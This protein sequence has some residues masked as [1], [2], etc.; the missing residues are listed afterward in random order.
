MRMVTSDE[1]KIVPRVRFE[2]ILAAQPPQ[3]STSNLIFDFPG[4]AR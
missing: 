2:L 3:R 4:I 1:I